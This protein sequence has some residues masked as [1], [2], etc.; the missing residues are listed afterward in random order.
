MNSVI[1]FPLFIA[2][3][4]A[5]S[6]LSA[7]AQ[8]TGAGVSVGVGTDGSRVSADVTVGARAVDRHCLRQTGTRIVSWRDHERRC[9]GFAGR[10]YSREE[11]QGTGRV[12]MGDALRALDPSIR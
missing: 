12:D 1:R 9:A 4:L 5:I 3:A 6:S 11:L 10:S 8:S 2:A 7:H